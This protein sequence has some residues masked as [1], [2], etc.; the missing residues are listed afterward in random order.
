MFALVISLSFNLGILIAFCYS[1]VFMRPK[2]FMPPPLPD[3][4]K[5]Q[6]VFKNEDISQAKKENIEIRREFF[7]ELAKSAVDTE[8]LSDI[9]KRL[10]DS[11][12]QLDKLVL[13]HYVNIRSDMSNEEAEQFFTRFQKRYETHKDKRKMPY[14]R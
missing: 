6:R 7:N 9:S 5:V 14:R 3:K 2:H 10:E 11:Q 8:K 12:T 13:Q 4:P 1:L